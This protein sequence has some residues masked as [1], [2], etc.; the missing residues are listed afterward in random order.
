[1]A[2][3]GAWLWVAYM[4]KW[5][6]IQMKIVHLADTHLG[7]SAYRKIS[8]SGFNQREEDV[9]LSFLDAVD[10]II[11]M[12]PDLVLHSGDLFDSV[13]PTNRIVSIGIEQMLRIYSAGI[14]LIMISGNHETPKQIYK[15]SIYSVFDALPLDRKL[16]NI[17]YKDRYESFRYGEVL[18]H[19]VPQC[20]DDKTFQAELKKIKMDPEAKNV[21]MLHCGVTGMKEFSHGESNELLVDYEW[22]NRSKFDYVALGHYHG[23]VKVAENAWFSGSSERMSFN[24]AGQAKGFLV[25]D[26]PKTG[27]TKTELIQVRTRAMVDMPSI[28]ASGKDSVALLQ[29]ILDAIKDVDPEG[30]IIR[31]TVRNIPQH[32]MNTLDTKLIRDAAKDA[33]HFEP[34]Y[35]R[36]TEEGKKEEVK[37]ASGG[38]REEFGS[39]IS[40]AGMDKKDLDYFVDL[41]SQEYDSIIKEEE[42]QKQ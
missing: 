12:K 14:P 25:V 6:Q 17:V 9:I 33:V 11:A 7:Y 5:P 24:E 3:S 34:R 22:L 42:E 8:E 39:F 31:M 35:E 19:A 32:V 13:R 41:W 20:P 4:I 2:F 15:G 30:K 16:F 29:E 21:L 23:H 1:M 10:R 18:V 38:M 37:I 36:I 40:A 26:I 27:K 28:D